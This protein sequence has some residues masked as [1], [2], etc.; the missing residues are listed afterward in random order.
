MASA[1]AFSNG[2]AA[3]TVIGQPD[4]TT[5]TAGSGTSKI[6]FPQ[7][8]TF[9]SAG[10]LWVADTSASRVLKFTAPLTNGM[11]ASTVI[12][13][14]DFATVTSGSGTDKMNNPNGVALDSSGNLLVADGNNN[15]VL[16][17]TAPL[18][19][20]MAASTVIGQPDFATVTSGSGT[21]KMNFPI[22]VALDSSGNLL[23]ADGNNNRV[24]KFTAS[25]SGSQVASSVNIAG[26]C[27]L[28]VIS[29]S[30]ISY[31][32][33]LPSATSTEKTV[34]LD[35]TGS[36]PATLQVKGTNWLDAT[37]VNKMN[38]DNTKFSTTS[39]TYASKTSLLTIDQTITGAFSPTTNLNS[40]WQMQAN[41]LDSSFSGALTQTMDFTATC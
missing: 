32:T 11:A 5:V 39:G 14:P 2:Q 38:V 9:D 36:I 28:S 6:T 7:G 10:N 23:V 34:V 19:N 35:N 3:S 15:R 26:T 8:A 41:L 30:P 40:L 37:L 25:T 1:F 13:Q 12:G 33:L 17:F 24:L 27:G 20:G 29:G 16:K 21:D 31:G 4:F 22:G 18:T